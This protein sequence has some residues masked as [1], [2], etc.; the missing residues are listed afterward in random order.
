[1]LKKENVFNQRRSFVGNRISTKFFFHIVSLFHFLQ[2]PHSVCRAETSKLSNT[3]NFLQSFFQTCFR[4][5]I[6]EAVPYTLDTRTMEKEARQGGGGE[7]GNRI[8]MGGMK[9][10]RKRSLSLAYYAFF[11]DRRSI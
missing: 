5:A 7:G 6:V 10:G 11:D 2:S 4:K 3:Q 8:F 9:R 1:M